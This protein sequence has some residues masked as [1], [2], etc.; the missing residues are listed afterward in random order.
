M[1]RTRFVILGI[2]LVAGTTLSADESAWTMLRK[3]REYFSNG[4]FR[5]AKPCF[6]SAIRRDARCTQAYYYLGRIYESKHQSSDAVKAYE[7]VPEQ[8]PTYSLAQD[9]LGQIA[10]RA[11]DRK[12][13]AEHIEKS[14]EAR[15][16]LDGWLQL[17]TI[18]MEIEEFKKAESALA[19][20]A[21]MTKG[22]VALDEL[23]ARL[24]VATERYDKALSLFESISKRF[25]RDS[26]ARCMAALCLSRLDRPGEAEAAWLEV[27]EKDPFHKASIQLL[28]SLWQDDASKDERVADLEKRLEMIRNSP[29]K[30]VRRVEKKS[31]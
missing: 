16:S 1:S 24:Y 11:G 17:A 4:D 21:K 19:K 12:K 29:P 2:L 22:D 25:P 3:G 9:R 18:L 31:R 20:A 23:R 5:R 28:L 13:A 26:N 30:V 27:L 7:A 14:V 10:L 6:E 15:P 8:D